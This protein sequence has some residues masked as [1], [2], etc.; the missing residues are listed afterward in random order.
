MMDTLYNS[1]F[2]CLMIIIILII[3]LVAT[4]VTFGKTKN[5]FSCFHCELTS[6]TIE[7]TV[8]PAHKNSGRAVN[9]ST[10][11]PEREKNPP[12]AAFYF[13]NEGL[14]YC[15]IRIIVYFNH[16]QVV[17]LTWI[18]TSNVKTEEQNRKSEHKS[19]NLQLCS[20]RPLIFCNIPSRMRPV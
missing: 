8:N 14:E 4:A 19:L 12:N 6:T 11:L 18:H 16:N 7:I 1:D 3:H 10:Q 17:R 13:K 9:F 2:N 15:I 5:T 20:F